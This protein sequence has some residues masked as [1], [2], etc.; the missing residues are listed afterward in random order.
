MDGSR[1]TPLPFRTSIAQ[2]GPDQRAAPGEI[3]GRS[4]LRPWPYLAPQAL[5][6]PGVIW[7]FDAVSWELRVVADSGKDRAIV[8]PP[9]PDR[10]T[11]LSLG[12]RVLADSVYRL[13]LV[14]DDQGRLWM[15]SGNNAVPAVNEF[16]SREWFVFEKDGRLLGSVKM[17][18]GFR[19]FDIRGNELLGLYR[20]SA[21]AGSAAAV[22]KF[23]APARR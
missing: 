2:I 16:G 5:V 4:T 14:V 21:F 15:D 19:P 13:E 23:T 11:G 8:R 22:F 20:P 12:S 10:L 9:L 1:R 17:P 7:L 18:G 6:G 3:P